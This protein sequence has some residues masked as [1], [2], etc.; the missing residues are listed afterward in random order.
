MILPL[1]HYLFGLMVVQDA[2]ACLAGH[3]NMDLMSWK[4]VLLLSTRINGAGTPVL[5]YFILSLQL[6]LVSLTAVTL[7]IALLTITLQLKIT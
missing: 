4:A 5:T 1:I 3:K 6:A 2:Q 7:K